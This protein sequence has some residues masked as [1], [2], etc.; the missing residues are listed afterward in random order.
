VN[1][2][3][4]TIDGTELEVAAGTTLLHAAQGL[5]KDIPTLCHDELLKP[6]ASC[7]LCVVEVE[8]R[9]NLLPSC[10]TEAVAGMKVR[11]DTPRVRDARKTCLELLM[12]DH[13]GDCLAPCRDTCPGGLNIPGFIKYLNEGKYREAIQVIKDRLAMPSMLGRVCPRPCE[14]SCRRTYVD[15]EAVAI[16]DLKRFAADQDREAEGGPYLPE[17]AA[18]TG[19][20]VAIVGAGPAGIAAAYYLRQWGHD[21]IIYDAHEKAGGMVRYGIPSYRLPREVLEQEIACAERLGAQVRCGVKVGR[22]VTLEQLRQDHDAVFLGIGAQGASAMQVEGETLPGVLSGIAF[23]AQV[24][25]DEKTP[26]GRRVMV[27]GGGNTAIDAA[28]TALRLGAAEVSILYRRTRAD[29]SRSP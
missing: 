8:G 19:K 9:A 12:S 7:Y 2:I 16:C 24:S 14:E 15:K 17:R 23:L 11:T 3:K 18:P 20:K 6:F 25:K 27:V 21:C 22:D 4:L 28:R 10:S 29:S 13:L 1:T 26:I 5:G